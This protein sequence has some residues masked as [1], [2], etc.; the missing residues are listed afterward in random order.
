MYV[1]GPPQA[2]LPTAVKL[3]SSGFVHVSEFAKACISFIKSSN[4]WRS[5]AFNLVSDL[6]Q[7]NRNGIAINS[8]GSNLFIM[9]LFL[10]LYIPITVGS[11]LCYNVNQKGIPF[12]ECLLSKM[13]FNYELLKFLCVYFTLI[14]SK[15]NFAQA[16]RLWCHLNILICLNVFHTFFKRE[17]HRWS[18]TRI[19]I[20]ARST[21]ICQLFT[22][23]YV[24]CQIVVANMLTKNLTFVNIH[25]WVYEETTSV[26]QFVNRISRCCTGIKRN[27]YTGQ[28]SRN[29]TFPRLITFKTVRHYGFTRCSCQYVITQ[30][31]DT[32]RRYREL[33][34]LHFAFGLHDQQLPFTLGN[35]FDYLS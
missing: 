34:V 12:T 27:Q 11:T 7:A 31:N 23:R 33:Q 3:H 8:I 35:K 29:S 13:L 28:S 16:D 30:S 14:F 24:D 19:V 32:A 25:A 22:F 5:T 9:L 21:H 20:R 18:D 1:C 2:L 15:I 26:L 6:S 10:V 17:F 4:S